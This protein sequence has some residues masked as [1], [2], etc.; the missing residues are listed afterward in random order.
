[1]LSMALKNGTEF[2]TKNCPEGRGVISARI[3]RVEPRY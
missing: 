2:P 3:R 1:M